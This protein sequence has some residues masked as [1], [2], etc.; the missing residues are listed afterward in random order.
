MNNVLFMTHINDTNNSSKIIII[1][2]DNNIC[3]LLP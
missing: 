3:K 1:F 2:Y